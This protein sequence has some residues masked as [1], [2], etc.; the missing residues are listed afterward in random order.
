MVAYGGAGGAPIAVPVFCSHQ[1]SPNWN[2][3]L[4]I[5]RVSASMMVGIGRSRNTKVLCRRYCLIVCSAWS[6][7]MLVYIETA[8]AVNKQAV[9]GRLGSLT[10]RDFRL[11]E[12]RKKDVWWLATICSCESSHSPSGC[13]MLPQ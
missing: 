4:R 7:S 11:C 6:V 13:R 8:S 10:R 5:T 3:V 12:L 9:G 1:V 2:I